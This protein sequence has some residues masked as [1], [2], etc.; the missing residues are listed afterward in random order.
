MHEYVF[1]DL[2]EW[3]GKLRTIDIEKPEAVLGGL[4][5]DYTGHENILRTLSEAVE[6][7]KGIP[8]GKLELQKRADLFSDC[9]ARI[10]KVHPFREGNTRT[11]THF[12]CQYADS[13]DMPINRDLFKENSRYL[14]AALAA[15]NAVFSE[16]GDLSKKEYLYGIVRDA[17][18]LSR[19]S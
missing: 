13:V 2:F 14:R 4:S 16:L 8:W 5:L 11:I 7:M 12:C 1:Q 9:F 19:T 17:M 10:W 6:G 3:A 18:G 15:A